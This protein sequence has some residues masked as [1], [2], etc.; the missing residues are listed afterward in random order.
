MHAFTNGK[1]DENRCSDSSC[2]VCRREPPKDATPE[3]WKRWTRWALGQ[4]G[5][6][7]PER[8]R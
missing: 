8:V 3:D 5:G 6:V 4:P 7:E 2:V 1:P